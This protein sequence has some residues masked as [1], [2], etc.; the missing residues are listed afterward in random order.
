VPEIPE[1]AMLAW[2]DEQKWMPA[3]KWIGMNLTAMPQE[4]RGAFVADNLQIIQA[5]AAHNEKY[6]KAVRELMAQAGVAYG[7]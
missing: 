7:D 3:W 2:V 1:E 5:V 6:A 4:V